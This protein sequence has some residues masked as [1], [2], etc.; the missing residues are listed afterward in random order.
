MNLD[1]DQH[2]L[3]DE[4][5]LNKTINTANINSDDIIFEIGPG[6]GV[7]TKKILKQ[8]PKKLISIEKDE[9]LKKYLEQIKQNNSNFQFIISDGT[10]EINNFKFTK[11]IA[12]IPYSITEPLYKKILDKKIEFALMLHGKKFYDIITMSHNKWY[13]FVNAFYNIELIEEVNGD[14]FEPKTKVKSAL[15]LLKLK[16]NLTQQ[17]ILL[18]TL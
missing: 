17:N 7:L 11:L 10:Q 16:Q 1:L 15:V 2:F 14:K 3:I 12:N 9:N 5:I 6:A 13:H 8:N 4:N 18:Q